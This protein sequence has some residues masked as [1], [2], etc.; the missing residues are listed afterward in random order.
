MPHPVPCPKASIPQ[1]QVHRIDGMDQIMYT[2]YLSMHAIVEVDR[3]RKVIVVHVAPAFVVGLLKVLLPMD[4]R[5]AYFLTCSI[6]SVI[7][8]MSKSF[9]RFA[10]FIEGGV[11]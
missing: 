4:K 9:S 6:D 11:G 1:G 10:L 2:A 5:T 3:R 8:M 7:P